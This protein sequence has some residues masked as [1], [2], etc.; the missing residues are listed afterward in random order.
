M[1]LTPLEQ[2]IR[3]YAFLHNCDM[4]E[5]TFKVL[6]EVVNETS[7]NRKTEGLYDKLFQ[8]RDT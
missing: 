3:N 2:R 8:E 1:N 7:K 4:D 5:A 6:V